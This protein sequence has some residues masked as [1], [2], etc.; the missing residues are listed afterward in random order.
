MKHLIIKWTSNKDKEAWKGNS[1]LLLSSFKYVNCFIMFL[2]NL[3]KVCATVSI[4]I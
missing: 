1:Y 4:I 3:F 2:N